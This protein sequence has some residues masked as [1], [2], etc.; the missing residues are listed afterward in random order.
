MEMVWSL[1]QQPTSHG[2]YMMRHCTTYGH[3]ALLA[4][5]AHACTSSLQRPPA[6][7]VSRGPNGPIPCRCSCVRGGRTCGGQRSLTEASSLTI[8]S[9]QLT[10]LTSPSKL[11]SQ[12]A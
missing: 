6:L 3:H 2:A 8:N 9:R 1:Q 11:A 5:P 4:R 7:K 12:P 10:R